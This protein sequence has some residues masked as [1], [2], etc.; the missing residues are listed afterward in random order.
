[1]EHLLGRRV[2]TGFDGRVGLPAAPD[3][4]KGW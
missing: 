4:V 3:S 1:M 2:R